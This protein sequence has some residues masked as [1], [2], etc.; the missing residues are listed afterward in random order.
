MRSSCLYCGAALEGSQ[1]TSLA[2]VT[3]SSPAAL[4]LLPSVLKPGPQSESLSHVV[5]L[6]PDVGRASLPDIAAVSGLTT[7]ELEILLSS[8]PKAA[9]LCSAVDPGEEAVADR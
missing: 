6:N 1:E 3:P 5:V 8:S 9:L 4:D 2:P 7:A